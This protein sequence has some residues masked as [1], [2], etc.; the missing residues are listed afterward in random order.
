MSSKSFPNSEF[1]IYRIVI[2]SCRLRLYTTVQG[3]RM[4]WNDVF[5][6]HCSGHP[7]RGV[8]D[9]T[10]ICILAIDCCK[11]D[12]LSGMHGTTIGGR[13]RHSSVGCTRYAAVFMSRD[14][15]Q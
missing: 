6:M 10:I 15:G 7:G 3:G 11:H 1:C 5:I 13:V 14:R 4:S 12:I 2:S 8:P 9:T